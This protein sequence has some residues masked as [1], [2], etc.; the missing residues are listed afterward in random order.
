MRKEEKFLRVIDWV[1]EYTTKNSQKRQ[2]RA[3]GGQWGKMNNKNA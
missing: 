2:R 1:M 3:W